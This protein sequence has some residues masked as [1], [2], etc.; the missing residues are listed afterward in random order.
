MIGPIDIYRISYTLKNSIQVVE[1][2]EHTLP[3]PSGRAESEDKHQSVG[4]NR[5][6]HSGLIQQTGEGAQYH[7]VEITKWG[8]LSQH[9]K[10]SSPFSFHN[11]FDALNYLNDGPFQHSAYCSIQRI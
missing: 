11:H 6:I 4:L 5:S 9:Q 7:T 8:R 10:L 3:W 2:N 1:G